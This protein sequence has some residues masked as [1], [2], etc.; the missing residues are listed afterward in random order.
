LRHLLEYLVTRSTEG[1]AEQIKESV[2]AVEVF[3]RRANFDGRID[4]IVRVQAHRLR[5]LLEAYYLDEGK[6]DKVRFCIPRGSYVPQ[7]ASLAELEAIPPVPPEEPPA[8][9]AEALHPPPILETAAHPPPPLSR[10]AL[11][12][13]C[14]AFAAGLLLAAALLSL[15]RLRSNAPLA[16]PPGPLADI[17]QP[18]FEPGSRVIVSF[19]N[20]VFLRVDRSRTYLLYVGP[21][22]APP[23]TEFSVKDND[24]DIDWQSVH[25]GQHL[26][27][28]DG[29]TGTGEVLAVNRLTEVGTQFK[30]H[31]DVIPSRALALNEMRGANVIFLG[32]PWMNGALAQ[33]G[34]GPAP[35]YNTNDGRILVRNPLPGEPAQYENVKD[36]VT[37]Q[38]QSCYALFSVMPGMDEGHKIVS[39]AGVG[40]WATW[41]GV[42]YV[43]SPAGAAQLSKTLIAANGGVMPLYYQAIIRTY[44][45]KGTASNNSLVSTR[46]FKAPPRQTSK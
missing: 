43:T 12:A 20:P 9:V 6:A 31:I 4:N 36:P 30:Q 5:K 13:V 33:I 18:V 45:I 23:G 37:G 19:T 25:K 26:F 44:L 17:W 28:N 15:V 38:I 11:L 16:V 22:S 46:I 7:L 41:A 29:W 27:F 14:T 2:L 42:D 10:K 8:L 1:H 3:G 34:S 35:M 40:T 32:S 24:P 39:S 21:L